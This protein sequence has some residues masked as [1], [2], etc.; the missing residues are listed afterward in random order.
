VKEVLGSIP[1]S[2]RRKNKQAEEGSPTLSGL[3]TNE[4]FSFSDRERLRINVDSL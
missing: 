1:C 3:E 2:K 4:A